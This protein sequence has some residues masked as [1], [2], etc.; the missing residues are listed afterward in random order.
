[1]KLKLNKPF[2][3]H[4]K[5]C[6][7]F[8]ACC[9]RLTAF[10]QDVNPLLKNVK[11]KL[12]KV[13][14]YVAE[15]RMRTDVAFIKA[16]AGNVKIFY[17]RPNKLKL[18][19]GGGISL[20]PKGGISANMSSLLSD[21]DYVALAAGESTIGP[22]KVRV[23]KLLP[24]KENSDIV[25]TTLYIDEANLLIRKASTTT[26]ENG[27]YETEMSYGK[28][29]QYGLPDKVIFSFNT[30]NFKLPKGLTME[31]DGDK[32]KT[33]VERMKNKKGKIEISYSA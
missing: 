29:S 19:R 27:T 24:T 17:K 30:K 5:V 4:L 32:K 13:N 20:L 33:D 10:S 3:S 22:I 1:M 12:D 15:G 18:K 8:A 9:L 11:D 2:L 21:G 28:Y 25:L 16:P 7:I 23:I 26:K 6:G 31:F 14:D